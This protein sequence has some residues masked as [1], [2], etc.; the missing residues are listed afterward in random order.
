MAKK[1]ITGT[2]LTGWLAAMGF[3]L[4]PDLLAELHEAWDDEEHE[5][6]R[7]RCSCCGRLLDARTSAWAS[8]GGEVVCSSCR[9]ARRLHGTPSCLLTDQPW[10]D[11]AKESYAD[12]Y[13]PESLGIYDTICVDMTCRCCHR[14]FKRRLSAWAEREGNFVC[15]QCSHAMRDGAK[16]C[17]LTGQPWWDDAAELYCDE[18]DPADFAIDDR[19]QIQ[20]AC[21]GCGRT[22]ALRVATWVAARGKWLCTGCRNERVW[23]EDRHGGKDDQYEKVVCAACHREHAIAAS[24]RDGHSEEFVCPGCRSAQT[25]GLPSCL[26]TDQPW[27]SAAE[28]FYAD[29]RD[30]STLRTCDDTKVLVKCKE[31]GRIRAISMQSFVKR[32]GITR[33]GSCGRSLRHAAAGHK[34]E[35]LVDSEFWKE[36]GHLYCADG[37]PD[38]HTLHSGAATRIDVLCARC[39]TRRKVRTSNWVRLRQPLCR[40]CA[41]QL[42]SERKAAEEAAADRGDEG[43]EEQEA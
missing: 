23:E 36:Y 33:C 30:P 34:S 22:R 31:C 9:K 15:P 37:N 13:P 42:R 29:E 43:G 28:P 17:L 24:Q 14:T 19:R 12:A 26:V 2:E 1:G 20:V 38:P 6:G 4:E 39:G 10:W 18:R 5:G 41:Q 35:L 27:W 21:A 25:R 8:S 32:Q 3:S 40:S 11:D 7:V 16:S